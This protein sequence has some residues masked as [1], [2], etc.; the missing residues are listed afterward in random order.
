VKKSP[1]IIEE[2]SDA[3]LIHITEGALP[4]FVCIFSEIYVL[5]CMCING[6][7]LMSVRKDGGRAEIE[8]VLLSFDAHCHCGKEHEIV[9]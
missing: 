7:S 5:T 3:Q 4:M 6:Q 9:Q 1:V 8:D 2:F